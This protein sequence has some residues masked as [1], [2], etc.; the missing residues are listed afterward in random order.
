MRFTKT[1]AAT[2]LAALPFTI[3]AGGGEPLI[4]DVANDANFV[5]TQLFTIGAA[6]E[7]PGTAN[8]MAEGDI[9]AVDVTSDG[10]A[11]QVIWT[12]SGPISPTG[13]PV[14]Y[15]FSGGVVPQQTDSASV[16]IRVIPG[17]SADIRVIDGGATGYDETVDLP[18]SQVTVEGDTVTFTL[19]YVMMGALTSYIKPGASISDTQAR[20]E[21]YIGHEAVGGAYFPHIDK[22]LNGGTAL[23]Q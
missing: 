2:A 12:M 1:I 8:I 14:V 19:P 13:A 23:L 7:A 11:F 5:N 15:T 20:T 18:L 22:A 10:D 21:M 16:T 6:P 9:V 4:T 3:A 17:S